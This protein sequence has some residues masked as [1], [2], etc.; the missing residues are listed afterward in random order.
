MA[1]I[2][3]NLHNAGTLAGM[4]PPALPFG[5][6]GAAALPIG[7]GGAGMYMIINTKTNNRYVGTSGDLA[8]RFNA[9]MGVITEMGFSTAQMHRITLIWGN[10]I[11][12]DTVAPHL[13]APLRIVTGYDPPLDYN[14][15]GVSIGLERLLIRFVI[16]QLGA[17]GTSSNNMLATTPYINPTPNPITVTLNWGAAGNL[18]AGT[19]SAVWNP[20]GPAW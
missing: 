2:T 19:S 1:T 7:L 6:F 15:D 12:R 8:Q 14:V 18:I 10:V 20:G 11:I 9:R 16:T 4:A 13:I 17:G 3:Y 5:G